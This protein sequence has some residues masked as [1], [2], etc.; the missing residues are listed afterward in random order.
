MNGKQFLVTAGGIF[1]GRDSANRVACFVGAG[2]TI[3][4][5]FGDCADSVEA[6]LNGCK[7]PRERWASI[8][9]KA[10]TRLDAYIV[11]QGGGNGSKWVR[12]AAMVVISVLSYGAASGA[13][14]AGTAGWSAGAQ[15][16]AGAA[17]SIIGGL[18]VTSIIPS[19]EPKT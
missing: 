7:V 12:L 6:H 1:E 16:A 14:W 3:A 13:S 2:T 18:A 19:P 11:P 9:P 4:E 15:V 8:R 17:I 5:A 10:G